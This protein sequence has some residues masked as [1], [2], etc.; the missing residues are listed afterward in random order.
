MKEKINFIWQKKYKEALAL[1]AI[2]GSIIIFFCSSFDNV[3]LFVT[4]VVVFWYSRETM[5]L[6]QISNKQVDHLRK[7]H[8]TNLR[9][10]LRLQSED[11]S[12]VLINDGKGVAVNLEPTYKGSTDK[13]FLRIPAMSIGGVTRS[14]VPMHFGMELNPKIN[15]YT[16]EI[17]YKD[18]ENRNYIAVFKSNSLFNDGFEIIRQEEGI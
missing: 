7:E 17:K 3:L 9:P 16:V 5:D 2:I 1:I 18:V 8:K 12:L 13:N 10:Y 14:F 11:N 6:K 4:L 15:D